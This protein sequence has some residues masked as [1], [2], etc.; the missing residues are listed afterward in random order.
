MWYTVCHSVPWM[1]YL[2][3]LDGTVILHCELLWLITVV[4]CI[5]PES[6]S[7]ML[8]Y[9]WRWI[10]QVHTSERSEIPDNCTNYYPTLWQYRLKC[11]IKCFVQIVVQ[12]LSAS[13]N[14]RQWRTLGKGGNRNI[15]LL[16]MRK[17]NYQGIIWSGREICYIWFTVL[18]PNMTL[19]FVGLGSSY[20]SHWLVVSRRLY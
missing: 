20:L 12:A 2:F 19:S 4:K 17:S 15:G 8:H 1:R 6:P 3:P 7:D 14:L 18:T 5:N 11:L 10:R 9:Q 13:I 16:E